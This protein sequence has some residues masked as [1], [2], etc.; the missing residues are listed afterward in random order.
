VGNPATMHVSQDRDTITSEIHIAARR[1]AGKWHSSGIP[2]D[3]GRG[4]VSG[5]F[6][7]GAST[8]PAA[9]FPDHELDR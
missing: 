8:T 9:S 4:E 6:L 5:E 2:P 1:P 3:G 7:Q